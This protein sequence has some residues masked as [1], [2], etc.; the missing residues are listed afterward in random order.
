MEFQLW[1]NDIVLLIFKWELG[2]LIILLGLLVRPVEIVQLS[3]KFRSH[4]EKN[5]KV[6]FLQCVKKVVAHLT[7]SSSTCSLYLFDSF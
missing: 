3:H 6:F 2:L 1:L 4:I 5:H 7:I